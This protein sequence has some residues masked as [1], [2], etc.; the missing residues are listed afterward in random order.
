[1]RKW[2]AWLCG[3]NVSI[4]FGG[5]E[6]EAQRVEARRP[7]HEH[8][9]GRDK[10][11]RDH[12]PR[13][14]PPRADAREDHVARH[15]EQ[16]IA[17][18]EDAGAKAVDSRREAERL[19][20]LQR[21]EADVDPIEIRDDVQEEEKRNQTPARL[22]DDWRDIAHDQIPRTKA[23]FSWSACLIRHGDQ[24]QRTRWTQR[25]TLP[26]CPLCPLCLIQ[27]R[28]PESKRELAVVATGEI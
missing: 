21:R 3:P 28:D 12:D 15:L 2:C 8:H 17:Q 27:R 11:P 23:H 26:W 16:P 5:A 20:H 7:A 18:K 14:P 24:T 1:M 22:R 13:D 25:N 10:A 4:C 6:Q 19:I 9:G